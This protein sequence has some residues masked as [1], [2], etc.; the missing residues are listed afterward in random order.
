[1]HYVGEVLLLG[2]SK[3]EIEALTG[4]ILHFE[5]DHFFKRV[6]FSIIIFTLVYGDK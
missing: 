1:M 5:H 2:S 3:K 6:D 4:A